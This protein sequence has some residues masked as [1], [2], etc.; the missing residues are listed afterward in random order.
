LVV[1]NDILECITRNDNIYISWLFDEENIKKDNV[2]FCLNE[3]LVRV[4]VRHIN[5]IHETGKVGE[6][7]VTGYTRATITMKDGTK[8]ILYAHPCWQSHPCYNWAYVHF[9]E[10]SADGIEVEN[11][12]PSCIIG[13]IRLDGGITEAMIQ[14]TEKPL[15]WSEIETNFFSTVKLDTSVDI[16]IVTVLM[17]TLVHSLC[18]LPETFT[19]KERF[20]VVLPTSEVE[21]EVILMGHPGLS[22]HVPVVRSIFILLNLKY[23]LEIFVRFTLLRM[24]YHLIN[25]LIVTL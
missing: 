4:L 25:F 12:Y 23:H 11:H 16:S 1:T 15:L 18:V 10:I 5:D 22:C 2:R 24:Y 19:S 17:S 9:Q 3:D 14:C 21:T 8:I 20:V 6:I 7:T 13:F